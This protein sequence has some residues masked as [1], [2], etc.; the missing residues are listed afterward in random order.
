MEFTRPG[1]IETPPDLTVPPA[2]PE[3]RPVPEG[4]GNRESPNPR[5]LRLVRSI[6]GSGPGPAAMLADASALGL[7]G[8][9]LGVPSVV[10]AAFSVLTPLVLYVGRHYVHRSSLATQGL[11][12]Y[13]SQVLA[14][15]SV[16]TVGLLVATSPLS[17]RPRIALLG[18]AGLGALTALR[19]VMWAVLSTARRAG[20]GL[21]RT[22]VLG[23]GDPARRVVAKL[24]AYPE[25][26]LLP[27]MV[28]G[29]QWAEPGPATAWDPE[30]AA[31]ALRSG[32]IRQLIV[33]PD[34]NP[35]QE[36][37]E[38]LGQ[39]EDLDVALLPPM[40]ELFM[41]PGRRVC[42]VGGLPLLLLGRWS[43]AQHRQPGKRAFDVI[44]S[45]LLI[46]LLSPILVAA[47]VAIRIGGGPVLY[48][49]RRVGFGGVPFEIFKFRTMDVGADRAVID[50]T[51]RNVADGLLFKVRDDP[52]VTRVGRVLRRLSVDELPQLFNVL[53]GQMSLVGPRPLAVDP[54]SFGTLDRRRHTVLPG[55]TGYWQ[56][57]GGNGLTYQEMVKLDL[58]YIDGWSLWLDIL[59]LGQTLPALIN[60]RG[61]W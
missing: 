50:L 33:I 45:A 48:R 37:R 61:P 35:E 2:R 40:A 15:Y 54:D 47:A 43:R 7:T 19:G 13:P 5:W 1:M 4:V 25:A 8:A 27:T 49:Q 26:G 34:G 46:A 18:L 55:I 12:W 14:G 56:V 52:R 60:R 59:L 16:A 24:L 58:A 41:A 42:R 10:V 3:R 9:V 20:A 29:P 38:Y 28:L 31:L 51:D 21:T 17:S 30:E 39:V 11:S 32:E 6:H 44:G 57:A 23:S 22:A 53:L 36:L